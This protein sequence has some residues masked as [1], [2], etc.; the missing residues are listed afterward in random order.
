M[1]SDVV[2]T[3]P[4]DTLAQLRK[5][6]SPSGLRE[7]PENAENNADSAQ[8]PLAVLRKRARSKYLTTALTLRLSDI[9]DTPLKKSYWNTFYCAGELVQ[10]GQKITGRYCNNRWC[11]TCNRIRT[12][13]LMKGYSAPL[14]E[15]PS[16]YFVTLTIP[17]MPGAELEGAIDHMNVTLKRIREMMRKR[18]TPVI[19]LRKLECTYNDQQDNFHPHYHLIVS[20]KDIADEIVR[21]WLERYPSANA[22]GQDVRPAGVNSAKELFKYFT[23]ILA[24]GGSRVNMGNGRVMIKKRVVYAEPLDLIFQA[25]RGKRVFQPMGIEKEVSED[26]EELQSEE[27]DESREFTMWKWNNSGDWIDETTGECLTGYNKS[28]AV[29]E[30]AQ[31]VIL[32]RGDTARTKPPPDIIPPMPQER[33]PSKSAAWDDENSRGPGMMLHSF[34]THPDASRISGHAQP[35]KPSVIQTQLWQ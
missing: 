7:R 22:K 13:K 20:G 18:K 9:P 23:K 14:A 33:D 29:E 12:A 35:R 10:D 1:V 25:M 31:S 19:G 26:I 5:V 32:R 24:S 27:L 16:K 21:Q 3:A 28:E 11:I 17:N 2:R 34:F 4:L 15:L 8:N 6:D 30:L